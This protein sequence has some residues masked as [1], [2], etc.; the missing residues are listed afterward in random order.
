M[1]TPN[2]NTHSGWSAGDRTAASSS[3]GSIN[4]LGSESSSTSSDED[5]LMDPDD[6][7]DPMLMT[8]QV[9]AKMGGSL[10]PNIG[11]TASNMLSPSG[12]PSFAS[13]TRA[14]LRKGRSRKSSSSA[15]GHSSLASP[16]PG[17]PPNTG[18]FAREVVMRKGGTRRE[19]LSMFTHDLNI[20]SGNDSGD[21]SAAANP[22]T[23]GVVRRPVVRRGNLLPKS[24]QFGR[25]KAELQE[26]SAPV[27][28]EVRR[29]AEIIRQVRESDP[30]LDRTTG[31]SSPTLLPTVPGLEGGLEGVPEEESE[32]GMSIDGSMAKRISAAFN[33]STGGRTLGGRGYWNQFDNQ[34]HTPPP[35][36]FPRAGSSAVSD[37]SMD[38]PSVS[39]ASNS[40]PSNNAM[41]P[42]EHF[43]NP[44]WYSRSS[45]P[46]PMAPVTAA[47]GLKKSNKRRRDDDLDINSIKRRAVSPSLSVQNSPI[48]SQSPGQRDGIL[49]G[50]A[51]RANRE[52]STGGHGPGERS[53]SAASLGATPAIGPKRIGLQGM[54]DTNDSLMKMTIKSILED[55]AAVDQA[56][57]PAFEKYSEE[58]FMTV[59]LPGG[60]EEVIVSSHNSL[61]GGRYYDVSNQ[62]SFSFDHASQKASGVQSYL[63]E[64]DH[65]DLVKS[66]LKSLSIHTAEHYPNSTLGV[67][68]IED[69]TQLAI[70]TVANKYS[71][72]NFWNGSWR[73]HYIY[74]PS[75]GSLTGS[76]K[77]DVHYYE[78]GNVRLLTDKPISIPLS[79][80]ASASEISRQIAVVEKKY[81]EDLNKAFTTLSEGAFK[82]LR[83]QL[84]ITRQKMDWEKISGYRVGQDIGGGRSR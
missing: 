10:T 65:S 44:G 59:K 12:I 16:G 72:S 43:N 78:D 26:E 61:G 35:P 46:Q 60:S 29:E 33:M 34:A 80:S 28:S 20:S 58:Q 47:E 81:Q 62:S 8:P 51:P 63:L 27:D 31:Q 54:T 19:S 9:K 24:R 75:S 49:W 6:N 52:G 53:N 41:A 48:L 74:S 22:T 30:D 21:D 83:R 56:L 11:G 69:D 68:P 45:T 55:D 38:S 70:V 32:S 18:L 67:Y 40:L 23:P 5:D 25:I 15:S 3:M 57:Y 17:S 66:L 4:M 84:P 2:M 42:A 36:S 13:I 14:R 7:D 39:S 77:V 82:S 64:S 73:S 79:S 71:P 76:I 50:N 1:D 37:V